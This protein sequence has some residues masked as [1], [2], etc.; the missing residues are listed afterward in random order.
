ML[1]GSAG[2]GDNGMID[3]ATPVYAKGAAAAIGDVA[4][5]TKRRLSSDIT[6][7]NGQL[8]IHVTRK[9]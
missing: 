2:T 7:Q 5:L 8:Q 3:A 1:V 4:T 6:T 9:F